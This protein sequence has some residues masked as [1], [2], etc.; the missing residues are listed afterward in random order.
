MVRKKGKKKDKDA[1]KRPLSAFLLFSKDR[2]KEVRTQTKTNNPNAGV[3][4]VAKALGEE[5]RNASE[6]EKDKFVKHAEFLKAQYDLVKAKYLKMKAAESGP[7]RP[8]TAFFLYAKA[9]RPAIKEAHPDAKIVD[10][11]KILGEEWKNLGSESKLS[12]Q[13]Q[14]LELKKEYDV[15][16]IKWLKKIKKSTF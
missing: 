5:W 4:D 3:T 2:R 8:P 15:A 16:K 11:A 14:A 7:K 9:R 13:E 1:P 6:Q 10:V 12:Y